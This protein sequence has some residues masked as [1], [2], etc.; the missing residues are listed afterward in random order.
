MLWWKC[1]LLQITSYETYVY[2]SL[3]SEINI[4]WK[5]LNYFVTRRIWCF[6]VVNFS[7]NSIVYY[8]IRGFIPSTRAF[9][10]L[11]CAFILQTRE[12]ELVTRG[13]ELVTREFELVTRLNS[14]IVHRN[15]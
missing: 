15:S 8:V 1:G 14:Q 2:Q 10:L 7:F 9:N 3:S 13:F 4:K 12:F 6:E 5:K 11:T